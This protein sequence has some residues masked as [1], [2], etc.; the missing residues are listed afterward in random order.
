MYII[1]DC[2]TT[3]LLN[4]KKDLSDPSQPRIISLAA[5]LV[6]ND[7]NIVDS[8][9]TL[10]HHPNLIIPEFITK[11]NGITQ[12]ACEEVGV[13]P[14]L[15]I[16]KFNDMKSRS[17]TRVAHNLSFDKQMIAREELALGMEHYSYNGESFC[18]MQMCRTLGMKGNLA[19]MYQQLFGRDFADVHTAMADTM[20]CMEIFFKVR[21]A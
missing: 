17:H 2:E 14:K 5:V 11:I 4:P 7:K 8:M 12:E 6:D 15:A 16:D 21:A 20:A 10:I 9:D 3:G 1:F 18:T 13:A 19:A